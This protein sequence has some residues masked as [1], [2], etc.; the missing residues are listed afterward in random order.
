M[1]EVGERSSSVERRLV[2]RCPGLAAPSPFIA[3]AQAAVARLRDGCI[4]AQQNV[5]MNRD[6]R[7]ERML[8]YGVASVWSGWPERD[9]P[10]PTLRAG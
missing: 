9:D 5:A 2:G 7:G 8:V 1:A 3:D 4:V 6:G 10:H